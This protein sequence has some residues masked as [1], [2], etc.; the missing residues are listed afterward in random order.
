MTVRTV[1]SVIVDMLKAAGVDR[2]TSVSGESHLGLLDALEHDGSID[3]VTYR[4]EGGAG[5]MA[6]ADAK[7]TGRIGVCM[8]GTMRLGIPAAAAAATQSPL[9]SS[10]GCR[11]VGG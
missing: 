4:H 6:V 8:V 2:A 3:V 10:T 5:L 7:L 11:P 1:A 9:M